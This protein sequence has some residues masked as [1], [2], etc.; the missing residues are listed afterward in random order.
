MH[1]VV[2]ICPPIYIK[3]FYWSRLQNTVEVRVC[4]IGNCW[5]GFKIRKHRGHTHGLI[6][7]ISQVHT[8]QSNISFKSQNINFQITI[9]FFLFVYFVNS[10][11][12]FKNL[13]CNWTQRQFS[14]VSLVTW[15]FLMWYTLIFYVSN[16]IIFSGCLD[17]KSKVSFQLKKITIQP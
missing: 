9:V 15:V 12:R 4:K 1:S 17:L 14:T 10:K 6:I 13:L 2:L 7:P 11:N 8:W 5:K 3:K 16:L